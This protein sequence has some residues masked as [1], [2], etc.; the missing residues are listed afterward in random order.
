MARH[1]PRGE[2]GSALVV[3]IVLMAVMLVVGMSSFAVVDTGQERAREQRSRE[4]ALNLAEGVLYSQG[5]VLAQTW[6]GNA[7]GGAALAS[8]CTPASVQSPCP[9]P[10]T[11]AA[12]NFSSPASANFTNA[13]V[14]SD[15]TWTTRIRDNGGAISDAFVFSQ[16]DAAQ[17]AT[18]VK[19][20]AAYTCPGPC[21]WDANGDL[22]L[23]VQARAVVRGHA[24]NLVALLKREQFAE[25]FARNGVTAGSFETANSGN[26]AIINA[27]GSQVVVRCTS[28]A[29]A[30]T[31]YKQDKGQVL[32][33]PIVRDPATPSAMSA[34]QLARF[35]AAAQSASPATYYTSCPPTLTGT[36][37]FIDLPTATSCSDSNSATYNSS[38]DPGIV[39]MPRGTLSM[40]GSLYG[41]VYMANEQNSAGTVLTLQANSEIF[42]GVAVDG[43][44]RLVVGSA[45]GERP[46]ITFVPDAFNSLASYGT[47][48]LVQN[49]WRELPPN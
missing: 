35:K 6:P 43:A 7:A 39:I 12:G 24:R 13:D 27:G 28:T 21:K 4:S 20:G 23:W 22:K 38:A 29:P 25:A 19:T 26:K 49:T 37:V 46:T 44:G 14:S 31:N 48:G 34:A 30:C 16:V 33:L 32:P 9:D 45:S 3:A 2:T 17:S 18:N 41:L 40:K 36:V 15:V 10:R 42:G 1:G 8:T 11:L 47:T 5:F